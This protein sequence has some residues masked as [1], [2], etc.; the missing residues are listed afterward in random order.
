MADILQLIGIVYWNLWSS[1]PFLGFGYWHLFEIWNL[2]FG[3]WPTLAA[4][5]TLRFPKKNG[6]SEPFF[7]NSQG[8]LAYSVDNQGERL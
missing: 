1:P 7:A 3:F 5:K 4:A 6:L 8:F 2:L